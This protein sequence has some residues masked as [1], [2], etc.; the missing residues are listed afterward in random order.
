MPVMIFCVGPRDLIVAV[1]SASELH[2]LVM[3]P[4]TMEDEL[5][6]E[7][8][9]G[10]GEEDDNDSSSSTVDD[11]DKVV[12]AAV[13]VVVVVVVIVAAE[14]VAAVVVVVVMGHLGNAQPSSGFR[15]K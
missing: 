14:S 5:V 10:L 13:V 6:R 9:V 12:V 3:R 4:E 15:L 7:E 2:K 8:G 1:Q 11:G